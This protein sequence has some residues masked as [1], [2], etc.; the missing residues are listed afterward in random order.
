PR[1]PPPAAPR[2]AASPARQPLRPRRQGHGHGRRLPRREAHVSRIAP[3]FAALRARGEVALVPY[4]TAGDP[5]LATTRELV[6]AAVAEGADAI[7]LG[8]PFSDPMA[9]G[10]V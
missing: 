9:D 4:F 5:D 3:T 2:P 6:L 10:P 1:V 8:V 7:E